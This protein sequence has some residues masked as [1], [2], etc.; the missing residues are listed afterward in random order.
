MATDDVPPTATARRSAPP[1]AARDASSP[2]PAAD[3][4]GFT[5]GIEDEPVAKLP[6]KPRAANR[7]K[8]KKEPDSVAAQPPADSV[9]DEQ[10]R[11]K[12]TICRDCK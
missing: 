11:R 12:L 2:K 1:L 5:T 6:A 8:L 9:E 10:L 4:D 7:S 3:Y